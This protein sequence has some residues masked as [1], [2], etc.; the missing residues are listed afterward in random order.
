MATGPAVDGYD[1]LTLVARGGFGV[2]YR[3][4][5]DRFDRVVALKVLNIG[6]LDDRGRQR[7]ERECRAMGN[8][9]WHPHVVAV[10]DSGITAEGHPFL[11]MEYLEA[12]SLAD[13]LVRD[14][15]LGWQEVLD[16]G[17][18]V[19]GALGAAHAAGTLH[20]DLK[21]ENLL[22][23][24]FGE[25]KLADFGIAAIEGS[26]KTT[27][28]HA[29]YT[30]AHV[31]PEILQ[32]QRP[33]ER[34]DLYGLAS[35][36]YTLLAGA[37][38]F[39][40]DLDEPIGTVITRVLRDPAPPLRDVP[41]A[42]ADLL[43]R[44]LAKDPAERLASAED[45]GRAL[46]QIQADNALAVTALRLAP[47]AAGAGAERKD[48]SPADPVEP[49]APVAPVDSPEPVAPPRRGDPSTTVQLAAPDPVPD[50][51]TDRTHG[52]RRRTLVAAVVGVAVL[53]GLGAA[54]LLANRDNADDAVEVADSGGA[55]T[56]ATTP[57]I[58][59]TTTEVVRPP[60]VSG[61]I[62]VG[63]A[64]SDVDATA[65]AVWVTSSRAGT[66]T[67]IDP[68]TDEAIATVDVGGGPRQ[69]V[70]ASNAVWVFKQ[71][72]GTV[73]RIDPA[74]NEV[75]ATVAVDNGGPEEV[76]ATADAAWVTNY[77]P[78]TITRID[79][80]SNEVTAT[81][82]LAPAFGPEAVAA[83][84]DTVWV[85]TQD[86]SVTRI[87]PATNRITAS[88]DTGAIAYDIAATADAV[89]VA[90][91]DG[92][93]GKVYRIDPTTNEV[94]ATIDIV[95]SPGGVAAR[96]GAVWVTDSAGAAVSRIDAATNEI[97][98]TLDV[99]G[100]PAGVA[101]AGEDVWVSN[102]EP[103]VTRIDPGTG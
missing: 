101:A 31:A 50:H 12:G 57:I 3:C 76:A 38:P 90:G 30:V 64:S 29:S 89:W 9:S 73:D 13:R 2:V 56:L 92:A 100:S 26:T 70:V 71:D 65:R 32:G 7:F 91:W 82:A 8:L 69:V 68:A 20:R 46:Q 45:L 80:A 39:V 72:D 53:A 19:C 6:D 66:V 95:F 42:L 17:V 25:A 16:L 61:T 1:G 94:V 15:P 103:T 40:R 79:A 14:G 77:D 88:I 67:H 52:R 55:A 11:A 97:S 21:P 49:P 35:T 98:D 24:P 23:G 102:L 83:T 47:T 22:I 74:T 51:G 93:A 41:G 27:A 5:Q 44:M 58:T 63:G 62:A 28:G 10:H 37:P 33:D 34:S 60:E 96:G 78:S 4:R 86:G 59:T 18:Q 48:R 87:D 85:G 54:A 36:L 99:G 84:S 81:V 75:V 43:D